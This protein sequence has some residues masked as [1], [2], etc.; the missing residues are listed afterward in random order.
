M[1]FGWA[2]CLLRRAAV[3]IGLALGTALCLTPAAGARSASAVPALGG[4]PE[5]FQQ[6]IFGEKLERKH[7]R[8]RGSP[9]ATTGPWCANRNSSIR[10]VNGC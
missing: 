2:S 4:A 6:G 7:M 10:T 3:I 8:R 5:Y 9:P 1:A